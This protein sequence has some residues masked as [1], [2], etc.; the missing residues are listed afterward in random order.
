[1]D[2]EQ[3]RLQ[4]RVARVEVEWN[5]EPRS[6]G[7]TFVLEAVKMQLELRLGVLEPEASFEEERPAAA[8]ICV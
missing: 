7:Q 2:P 5:L 1:M 6:E 8:F 3:L 4:L